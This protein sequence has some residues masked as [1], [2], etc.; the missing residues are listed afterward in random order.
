MRVVVIGG[1]AAGMS[2]ASQAK[3]RSP[4]A[5]VVV[6]ERGPYVSY[7]A[8]GTPYNIEDPARMM[9]DLI[10]ISAERF[11]TER[12]IDVRLGHAAVAI[13]AGAKRVE[14]EALDSGARSSLGYER[15][16]IATG[17]SAVRLPVPGAELDGIFTLRELTDGQALKRALAAPGVKRVAVI[18]GGYIGLEMCE[19]LRARGFEVTLIERQETVATGFD[20]GLARL[21]REEL[22]RGGV[23]VLT[24]VA[25]TGFERAGGTLRVLTGA[26]AVEADVALVAVG[27]RPNVALAREAGIALGATGAIATDDRLR[28]N[29]P[30][31]FAAGDCAEAWHLVSERPAWIPLGTTANK[32]GKL[33]GAGAVGGDQRFPGVVGTSAF[34]V[35]GLEVGRT[36]LGVEEARRLG[37]DAFRSESKQ[38]TRAGSYPGGSPA[39]TVLTVD[40]R[41]G[42]L[43]GAQQVAREGVPGRVNVLAMALT[44]KLTVDALAWLDLAYAPPFAPVYDPVLI[45]GAVAEKELAARRGG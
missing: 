7:G 6:L 42:R 8:C 45:A 34:K 36:G 28:T 30:D 10:A 4:D 29:L 12:R 16:I 33:A 14:V 18:G 17:A 32:Q 22:E 5:E 26:G 9:E 19:V 2:A 15:L 35:F 37:F 25:V 13:D 1:V 27:V 11:R 39:H 38:P 40:G 24:S 21:V 31:I 44:A 3:R 20:G 43:L 41:T 23:Q